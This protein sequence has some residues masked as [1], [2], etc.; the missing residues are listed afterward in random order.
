MLFAKAAFMPETKTKRASGDQSAD[1]QGTAA[2]QD[3]PQKGHKPMMG[4]GR[5]GGWGGAGRGGGALAA[6][7]LL[8]LGPQLLNLRP[9]RLALLLHLGA[10]LVARRTQGEALG[11]G[12]LRGE[13]RGVSN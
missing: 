4:G 9:K 5:K 13:G 6:A 8:H 10:R 2:P 7:L 3:T 11:G 12:L 1:L